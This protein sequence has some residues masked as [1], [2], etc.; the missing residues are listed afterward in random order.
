[1][2]QSRTKISSYIKKKLQRDINSMCPFCGTDKVEIFEIHHMDNDPSNSVE[3]NLLMLCA[4]CHNEVTKGI[5]TIDQ[6]QEAKKKAS[7]KQNRIAFVSLK[8]NSSKC[9][10][11]TEN[12]YAFYKTDSNNKSPHPILEFVCVNNTA[13]TVV[14]SDIELKAKLLPRGIN[15]ILQPQVLKSLVRYHIEIDAAKSVNRAK[16]FDEI[17]IPSGKAFKIEIEL[18]EKAESGLVYPINQRVVLSFL[19]KF[20][21]DLSLNLPRIYLNCTNDNPAF[22]IRYSR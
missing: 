13:H 22:E 16:V 18:S 9:S 20:N 3:S 14:F 17:E 8:V 19:F 7:P 1:M 4:N 12:E 15:G 21:S 10:W 6:V 5:I 11:I 2:G